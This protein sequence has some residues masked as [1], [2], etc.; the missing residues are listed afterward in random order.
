MVDTPDPH[1]PAPPSRTAPDQAFD[2]APWHADSSLIVRDYTGTPLGEMATAALAAQVVAE[3]R[4][5][6]KVA[7]MLEGAG[8]RASG[9]SQRPSRRPDDA[10]A[11]AVRLVEARDPGTE[12]IAVSRRE[13][14]VVTAERRQ[15]E[16]T[17]DGLADAA[18]RLMARLAEVEA[19]RDRFATK[20]LDEHDAHTSTMAERDQLREALAASN[21]SPDA[22]APP[23]GQAPVSS[24]APKAPQ[25]APER[26]SQAARDQAR[27][28]LAEGYCRFQGHITHE[29]AQCRDGALF[30]DRAILDA[31]GVTVVDQPLYE[32]P[33]G[34]IDNNPWRDGQRAISV[35]VVIRLP[36][37]P[38]EAATDVEPPRH[39]E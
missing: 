26:S 11:I 31:P 19:D 17:V 1:K 8:E 5:A 21:A 36:A 6:C 39:V 30:A 25:N 4:Y 35:Q 2:R 37:V 3:H 12:H 18:N 23:L 22:A 33:G 20:F 32:W 10:G 27:Q 16:H 9:S 34:H 28:W 7:A 38:L 15:L 13:W 24:P 14:A 29:P